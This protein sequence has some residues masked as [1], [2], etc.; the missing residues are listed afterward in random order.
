VRRQE[1]V[2]AV[3][4][5]GLARKLA[6]CP[7]AFV[8]YE[9]LQN[10]W[11]EEATEVW[12]IVTMVGRGICRI[13]VADNSPEGFADL[14]SVYTLFRDSKKA[15]DP[16]KRGRFE[17]GEKLVLAL[18]VRAKI[19]STKGTIIIEGDRRTSSKARLPSGTIF[20]ADFRFTKDEHEEMMGSMARLLPPSHCRTFINGEELQ[21]RAP[22]HIFRATLPTVVAD[23]DGNLVHVRR[24]AEVWMHKPRLGEKAHVYEMGIPVSETGDKWHCDVRQRVPINWER[25][26]VS[27]YYLQALR[28]AVLNECHGQL[29][30]SDMTASWVTETSSDVRITKYALGDI[31]K[32]RFGEKAVIFDPSD[33]EANKIAVSKGYT[34]IPGGALPAGMTV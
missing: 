15:A 13:V 27:P 8:L 31:V 23:D 2:F 7:K 14:S 6:S 18:A 11:D 33:P 10:A 19:S 26:L 25:N 30:K 21:A 5:A 12:V 1:G 24:E 17:L 20:E 32:M 4:R 22:F 3:D 29:S 28:V 34:V 16:A 9:L